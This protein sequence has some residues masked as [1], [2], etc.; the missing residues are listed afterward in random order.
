MNELTH[1]LNR[2]IVIRA[3]PETVFRYFTDPA[4]WAAW[5]GAGSTIDAKPGGQ[6]Y[7]RHPNGIESRGEVLSVAAPER[8]VFSYGFV[9]GKPMP[10]GASR[11]TIQLEPDDDGTRLSLLHEFDDASTRDEHVQGWRFQLSLFSNA[12]SNEAFA[13]AAKKVDAW[14]ASWSIADQ[15]IR[16]ATLAGIA[17][18]D[19]TFCDGFSALAGMEDLVAHT[20][21]AQRF[22]PGITLARKGDVRQCQGVVLAD[23]TAVDSTSVERMS[24]TNVFVFQKDGKIQSATG[25]MNR[26]S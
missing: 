16:A 10:P 25:F 18:P 19:V 13:Q 9:S 6:V 26:D 8:I 17:V 5:W 21:A 7:I 15:T 22:M 4:R 1:H 2:T 12:V 20:G 11:V 14:F 23:W 3:L 24:G